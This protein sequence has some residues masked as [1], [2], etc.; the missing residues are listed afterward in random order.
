MGAARSYQ[1][2]VDGSE[3]EI[4][5]QTRSLRPRL[6]SVHALIAV[7]TDWGRERDQNSSDQ[8]EREHIEHGVPE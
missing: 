3:G 5:K 2:F 8:E 6:P 7:L 4:R 1:L